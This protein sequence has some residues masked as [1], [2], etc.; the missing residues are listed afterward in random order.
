MRDDRRASNDPARGG[1]VGG[2][3]LPTRRPAYKPS[4]G[5]EVS[6]VMTGKYK[7]TT[8]FVRSLFAVTYPS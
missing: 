7:L 2:G 3:A 6:T 5:G 1:V 8:S 4:G